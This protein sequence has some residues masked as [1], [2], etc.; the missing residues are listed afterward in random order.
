MMAVTGQSR[1]RQKMKR[2]IGAK[3]I[4]G[5]SKSAKMRRNI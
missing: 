5:G 2:I 4:A 3:G 1:E